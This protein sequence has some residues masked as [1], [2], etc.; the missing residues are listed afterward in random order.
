[1]KIDRNIGAE[2]PAYS[3][4]HL[5][6]IVNNKVVNGSV[7]YSLALKIVPAIEYLTMK[8]FCKDISN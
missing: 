8:L 5:G 4:S 2:H 7:L 6:E 1:M 3:W